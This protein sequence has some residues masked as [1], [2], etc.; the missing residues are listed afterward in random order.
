MVHFICISRPK[1][2]KKD[3]FSKFSNKISKRLDNFDNEILAGDLNIDLSV[4]WR[5]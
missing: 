5:G 3:F 2:N 4:S 1:F